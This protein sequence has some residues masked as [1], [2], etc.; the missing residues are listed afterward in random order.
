MPTIY[1][2]V[3]GTVFEGSFTT[4][5]CWRRF[6]HSYP[7]TLV[8]TAIFDH[9][10]RRAEWLTFKNTNQWIYSAKEILLDLRFVKDDPYTFIG[11]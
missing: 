4:E 1:S 8:P 3:Q 9:R 7:E 11:K 10:Y 6:C 5:G 2:M